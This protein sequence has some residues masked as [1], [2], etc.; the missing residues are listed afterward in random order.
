MEEGAANFLEECHTQSHRPTCRLERRCL[1]VEFETCALIV[2]CGFCPACN[3][4]Q[5]VPGDDCNAGRLS[6]AG[7]RRSPLRAG[8][9]L[10]GC[11]LR[12]P[13]RSHGRLPNLVGVHLQQNHWAVPAARCGP[14][15]GRKSKGPPTA[16]MFG[17][18]EDWEFDEER[19]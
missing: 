8:A 9:H 7:T 4:H 2:L 15:L 18:C 12:K 10:A 17:D 6:A 3:R 19:L 5:Y 14:N 11:L 1:L 13:H 16:S